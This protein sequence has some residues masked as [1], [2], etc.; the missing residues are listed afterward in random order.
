MGPEPRC[1]CEP[2]VGTL[3]VAGTPKMPVS[4][5]LTYSTEGRI[6]HPLY[7][8]PRGEEQRRPCARTLLSRC[9]A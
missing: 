9:A 5:G 1:D 6:Q 8:E 3:R 4:Q 7:S 2:T